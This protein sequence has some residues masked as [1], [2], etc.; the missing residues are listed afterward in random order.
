MD[1]FAGGEDLEASTPE[2][3]QV[4][5]TA[6]AESEEGSSES[7]SPEESDEE[8]EREPAITSTVKKGK[9]K[10]RK[11][12]RDNIVTVMSQMMSKAMY[13]AFARARQCDTALKEAQNNNKNLRAKISELEG[14]PS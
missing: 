2:W 10:G 7:D 12:S 6:E 9:R 13:S 14:N 4:K 8:E 5:E 11:K 1:S 3:L